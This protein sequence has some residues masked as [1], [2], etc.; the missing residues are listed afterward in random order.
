MSWR[1]SLFFLGFLGGIAPEIA[2]WKNI[3]SIEGDSRRPGLAYI[4]ISILY[5]GTGAILSIFLAKNEIG[6]LY[7]GSAWPVLISASDAYIRKRFRVDSD[8]PI[9]RGAQPMIPKWGHFNN[10]LSS[11]PRGN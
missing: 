1:W 6:A 11:V 2:R 3:V 7:V 4:M 10:F 9:E 8:Q 5:A